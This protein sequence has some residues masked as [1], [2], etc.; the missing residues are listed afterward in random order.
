MNNELINAFNVIKAKK[1]VDL[2]HSFD[3]DSPH[4]FMFDSAEFKTLFGYPEGFLHSNLLSLG[5]MEHIL[6]LHV[7]L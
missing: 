2:T 1:W 4:F 7:T 6:M 5:N 3:K